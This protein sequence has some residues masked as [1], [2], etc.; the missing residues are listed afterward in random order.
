MTSRL[1]DQRGNALAEMAIILPLYLV[2][3][4]GVDAVGRQAQARVQ[5]RAAARYL[6]WQRDPVTEADLARIFF[7]DDGLGVDRESLALDRGAR[8]GVVVRPAELRAGI[9]ANRRGFDLEDYAAAVAPDRLG[10]MSMLLSHD[11][12]RSQA[13]VEV[14]HRPLGAELTGYL[15][16]PVRRL[17]AHHQVLLRSQD[18]A[19]R[20]YYRNDRFPREGYR[21]PIEKI[22]GNLRPD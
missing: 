19:R 10:N 11:L 2:I 18:E 5:V 1:L 6:A 20:R 9:D 17:D 22:T 14:D 12:V 16:F 13:L 3:I 7:D 21:H 4:L 15:R 8:A